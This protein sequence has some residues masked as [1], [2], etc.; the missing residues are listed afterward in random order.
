TVRNIGKSPALNV[1]VIEEVY[2]ST[3]MPGFFA[4]VPR[5]EQRFCEASEKDNGPAQDRGTAIFPDEIKEDLRGPN[6]FATTDSVKRNDRNIGPYGFMFIVGCVNYSFQSSPTLHQTRFVYGIVHT[7]DSGSKFA[8]GR[9][10]RASDLSS[11]RSSD[12]D[13][14]Y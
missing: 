3:N 11:R 2:L 13:Y 12:L 10:Y 6:A 9:N 7:G 1:L 8:V 4:D 5:E 14:V